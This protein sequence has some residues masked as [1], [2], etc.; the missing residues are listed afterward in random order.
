[1]N[2]D[3]SHQRRKASCRRLYTNHIYNI[4]GM[5]PLRQSLKAGKLSLTYIRI[6]IDMVFKNC[7][8]QENVKHKLQ[9]DYSGWEVG[10]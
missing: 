10:V 2:R 9:C 6:H 1:M 3:E 5:I 7:K 8:D 4:P